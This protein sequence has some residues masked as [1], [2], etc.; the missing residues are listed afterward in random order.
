M[1]EIAAAQ[2]EGFSLMEQLSL[3][4]M[5]K[6]V[7]LKHRLFIAALP[8]AHVAA[9]VVSLARHLCVEH[10]LRGTPFDCRRLRISMCML[11]EYPRFPAT[12]ASFAD[13]NM[14]RA[15]LPSCY[16]SFDRVLSLSGNSRL[17]RRCAISLRNSFATTDL[18]LLGNDI[19]RVL[20]LRGQPRTF[21]PHMTL[22][23]DW[24]R[25]EEEVRSLNGGLSNWH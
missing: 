15:V 13:A 8:P 9:R 12:L 7:L 24:E 3:T 17:P 20:K 21:M 6:P 16:A 11:G 22:L 4:G 10:N 5:D 14:H 18:Q 19:A 2:L 1:G 23:Y 25:V